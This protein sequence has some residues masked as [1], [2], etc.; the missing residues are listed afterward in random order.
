MSYFV[1]ALDGNR[2]RLNSLGEKKYKLNRRVSQ[3]KDKGSGCGAV[4]RAVASNTR[5]P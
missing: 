2:K 4:C 5:G 1:V 3:G